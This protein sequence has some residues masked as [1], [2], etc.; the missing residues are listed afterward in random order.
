MHAKHVKGPDPGPLFPFPSYQTGHLASCCQ[1]EAHV[2][3]GYI[4]LVTLR[5]A[6]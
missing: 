3:A 6:L 4:R 5:S 2:I 1:K